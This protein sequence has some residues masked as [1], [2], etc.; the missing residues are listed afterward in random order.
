MVAS[1]I[2]S[3]AL[4]RPLIMISFLSGGH[5]LAYPMYSNSVFQHH[6]CSFVPQSGSSQLCD[7]ERYAK[8][9]EGYPPPV[10]KPPSENLKSGSPRRL[11]P[12]TSCS[13]S[14]L[15]VF[16]CPVRCQLNRAHRHNNGVDLTKM[17]TAK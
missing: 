16:S 13:K 8:R 1:S 6:Y 15:R 12:V 17:L 11:P 3:E 2:R 5:A 7:Q 10:Q 9:A 4:L 14:H